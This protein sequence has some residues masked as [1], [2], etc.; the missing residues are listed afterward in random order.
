MITRMTSDVNQ[1]QSGVNMTLRLLLRSPIVVFGATVMAFVVDWAAALVFVAVT[2]LLAAAVVGIMRATV[3]MYKK[4]Q[5]KMDGVYLAT[6][7]N[8]AGV[9]VI[10]AFCKEEDEKREFARRNAEL[11]REQKLAGGIAALTNPITYA[12]VSVASIALV[13]VGGYRVDTGVLLQGD[14]IA[15]YSYLSIILVELVKFA[16]LIFTA[17]KAISCEKRIEAVLERRGASVLAPKRGKGRRTRPRFRSRTSRSPIMAAALPRCTT[18]RSARAARRWDPRRD[19]LGQTTLVTFCPLLSG[20]PRAVALRGNVNAFRQRSCARVGVVPQKAVLFKGTIRSNLCGA[21]ERRTRAHAAARSPRRRTSSAKGGLDAESRRRAK[22]FRAGSV[23]VSRSPVRWC[24]PRSAHSRRQLFRARLCD[25]RT[26]ERRS[27]ARLHGLVV[28]QRTASVR[29]ADKIVVLDDGGVAGIGTHESSAAARVPRDR[30]FAGKGG[31]AVSSRDVQ[32]H[33]ALLKPYA[34]LLCF[35]CC[36]RSQCRGAA[37]RSLSSVGGRFHRRRGQCDYGHILLF[38][39][40]GVCI[41]A[42][43]AAQFP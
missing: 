31:R 25:G 6:H 27:G 43:F 4:V 2:P 15:L 18:S 42:A 32:R 38:F 40:I 19:G 28:S 10:R 17:S 8:L 41:A 35:R 34:P 3:P 1:V 16:N 7:E 33:I 9:R 14:V 13:W 5:G 21:G 37:R 30:R 36:A 23:S 20:Q 22:T 24:A 29:H 39:V 11:R 12:L 26:A